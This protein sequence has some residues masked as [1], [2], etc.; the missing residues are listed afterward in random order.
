MNTCSCCVSVHSRRMWRCI[1]ANVVIGGVGESDGYEGDGD[2]T[3]SM[4]FN[5][6][7]LRSR[8]FEEGI[9]EELTKCRN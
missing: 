2:D 1:H 8:H 7:R 3:A 6:S 5:V 4:E 9:P